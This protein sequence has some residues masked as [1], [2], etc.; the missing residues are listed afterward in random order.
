M[1]FKQ[2]PKRQHIRRKIIVLLKCLIAALVTNVSIRIY[3]SPDKET[4]LQ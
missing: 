3:H 2:L 4:G 1:V